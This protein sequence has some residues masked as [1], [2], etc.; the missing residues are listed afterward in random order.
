MSLEEEI[1]EKFGKMQ[2]ISKERLRPPMA[3]IA[4]EKSGMGLVH[5]EHPNRSA[6]TVGSTDSELAIDFNA[7]ADASEFRRFIYWI[8]TGK[9]FRGSNEKLTIELNKTQEELDIVKLMKKQQKPIFMSVMNEYEAKLAKIRGRK[10][11]D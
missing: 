5:A 11:E 9:V 10:D 8:R 7:I 1:R 2:D 6:S 4:S 3:P